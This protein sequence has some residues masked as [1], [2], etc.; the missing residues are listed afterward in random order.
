MKK[1][2]LILLGLTMTVSGM[3]QSA[4]TY[5][6][7]GL[8]AGDVHQTRRVTTVEPGA[9]GANV[10]WDFSACEVTGNVHTEALE[11]SSAGGHIAVR[12]DGNTLFQFDVTPYGNDYYGYAANGYSVA[13]EKPVLKTRYPFGFL[14]QHSGNFLGYITQGNSKVPVEGSYSS[15]VDGYGTLKLPNG[16]T[17]SNVLRVKTT[18]VQK[19]LNNNA[20]DLAEE[21]YL[22]YSQDFRYPVFVII[23]L[24][25]NSVEGNASISKS[26]YVSVAALSAPPVVAGSAVA[27]NEPQAEVAA[28]EVEHSV[29][30]N[31]V[32][33]AANITYRLPSDVKVSVAVYTTNGVCVR[34]MV[35]N[36]VQAAGEYTYSYIPDVVGTYFIRFA[37]GSKTYTEQIV[38]R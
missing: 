14:D 18:E 36:E 28:P 17:L 3:A 32:A 4:I 38:K 15:E 33:D 22:W 5:D 24:S 35:N 2:V 7:H 31:P 23:L 21:K 30:P 16:V 12:N 8:R 1:N 26:S 20:Y 13:Y 11:N 34:K 19:R 37:F 6:K 10:T 27:D 25:S 9:S 29:Y